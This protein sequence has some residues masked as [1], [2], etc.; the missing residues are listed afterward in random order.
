MGTITSKIHTLPTLFPEKL[1]MAACF[2]LI[3][4]LVAGQV[5]IG[6]DKAPEKFS[7]LQ[8][9]GHSG[10]LRL[11]NLTTIERNSL[12]VSNNKLSNG[13]VIYNTDTKTIEVWNGTAW[14]ALSSSLV[15]NGLSKKGDTIQLE[16]SL[17]TSTTVD[18]K[19]N[20]LNFLSSTGSVGIGTSSPKASLHVERNMILGGAPA[21]YTNTSTLVRNNT[22]GEIGINKPIN[23]TLSDV[24]PAT[25]ATV[26][27]N[28]PFSSEQGFL[29]VNTKNECG[30]Q[31][32]A[33]FMFILSSTDFGIMLTYMN[34]MG[35][36]VVGQA[37]I[38]NPFSCQIKFPEVAGCSD[39]GNGTQFDFTVN[40]YNSEKVTITNNGN[41]NRT[42]TVTLSPI[43]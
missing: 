14:L 29:I 26:D 11:N 41:I 42:Y 25:T 28:L 24:K 8:L 7:T 32:N 37:T 9:E 1:I 6:S 38:I 17:N 31:M 23:Y 18:L 35:R 34:S 21:I 4:Q 16:G 30:R 27:I 2:L 15:S 40:T 5:T 36:D 22:T 12:S 39:G 33:V 19:T 20:N 3:S 10:G 43:L 13:L